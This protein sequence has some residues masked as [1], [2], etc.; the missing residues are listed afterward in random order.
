MKQIQ[1][2]QGCGFSVFL[3]RVARSSQPWA[4]WFNPFGIGRT[5]SRTSIFVSYSTENSE[6]PRNV[7]QAID[8]KPVAKFDLGFWQKPIKVNQGCQGLIERGLNRE[9]E[10]RAISPG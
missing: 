1:P 6:E 7:S 3:P 5:S 8:Y 9:F 10:A 4:E 2:L